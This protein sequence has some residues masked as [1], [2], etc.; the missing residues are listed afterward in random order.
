MIP[1]APVPA[2]FRVS[3]PDLPWLLGYAVAFWVAH[4]IAS[5]W[6]GR[7]FYSLLY[8]A[9]GFRMALLWRRGPR[10][11]PGL[12]I[13]EILVQCTTG[14]IDLRSPERAIHL[15]G[16]IR[17]PLAYSLVVLLVRHVAGRAHTSM[18]V[19][20]MPLGLASVGAPIAAALAA[21]PWSLLRPDLTGVSGLRDVVTSLTGFVVGDLLG[22][23]LLTPPLLWLA[24]FLSG[25]ASRPEKPRTS[26]V[27]EAVG[28]LATSI[29]T[30]I[31]L[32]KI[33]LGTPHTPVLLAV[34]WIGLRSGRTASWLAIAVVAAI[35]LP[36]TA[37][38][39]R[40][41][42]RLALHMSLAS[43]M[44]V[45]YLAGSFAD[46][47]ARARG[48]LERRDRLLF[49][50]ERLK[51]LRA[52]SVA[53]I[54]EISQPLSTL[55]IEAKHLHEITVSAD[56][57]IATTAALIDRK[58]AALST[59]VRRLRRFGGRAVDE[60]TPLPLAALIDTVA[61]LA[62]PEAKSRGVRLTI[63][64]VD[65]DLVVLAQEVELA[66][67]IVNLVRNAVQARGD[68]Q[69]SLGVTSE[70]G[71]ARIVV[72]N[73]S[74][75]DRSPQPGMGIGVLVA[76]AIVEAHGGSL[77]RASDGTGETRATILLPLLGETE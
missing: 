16:V 64:T 9:A 20:P 38:P 32:A 58:A 59:L 11:L 73:R 29:G 4:H 46:A 71:K 45:G 21:L 26:A 68:G 17:P 49:Q 1:R 31:L 22:V 70:D 35:V 40:M 53:V 50:A 43:I 61:A 7:G 48:D 19:A 60:P 6:G 5:E 65:P 69:V 34:A 10:L 72:T 33:G 54:H 76:R 24:E 28:V 63:E 23:L 77:T 18:S 44:V 51:T 62:H 57:E 47:Q 14:V 56:P 27:I 42:E 55:A 52:M 37:M 3:L 8:P 67:A 2:A 39:M 41:D 36:R 25:T 66:Q 13:A 75:P 74:R 15:T 30:E 12:V